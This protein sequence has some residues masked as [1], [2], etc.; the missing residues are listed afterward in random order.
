MFVYH[1]SPTLFENFDYSKVGTNGT[2]EGK[3]MYF[4]D[5][6]KIA[7][8][9]A[10]E[11]YLYKVKFS[12]RKSLSSDSLTFSEEDFRKLVIELDEETDYLSNWGDTGSEP[13]NTVVD[14]AVEGEYE[15]AES[16][17]DLLGS[18][19]NSS[20]DIEAV[21]RLAYTLLGYDSIVVDAEWGNQRLY[22]ALVQDVI[23]IVSV[24]AVH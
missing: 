17:T 12:G 19:I 23:D 2:A 6:K 7:E 3:G 9:Y 20:G 4:T 8:S 15:N 21:N 1:G 22:I 10:N 5:N 24:E 16:D 14:Y 11:G 13:L 18:L